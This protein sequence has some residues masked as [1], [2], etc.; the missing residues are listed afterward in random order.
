MQ[1][2]T[3]LAEL[4]RIGIDPVYQV[5]G[6][7]RD[8]LMGRP[9]SDYDFTTSMKPEEM[10]P[11]IQAAGKK[12]Y[13]IQGA[14]FGVV[15]ISLEGE[16]VEIASFR[17]ESYKENSRH[18]DVEYVTDITADL[19]RRDFSINAMAYRGHKLIDPFGGEQDIEAKLIRCVGSPRQRFNEDPLRMLR[20]VRFMAQLKFGIHEKTYT[21]IWEKAYKILTVSKERWMQE[22]DKI[23]LSDNA[24]HGLTMMY[25]LR[26]LNFMIPELSLQIG[27]DQHN[28]HHQHTLW[29]HTCLVV[30]GVPKDINLRW[31]ALL[32]DWAK[33]FIYTIK[34][35]PYR[36]TY[37]GHEKLGADMADRLGRHLKW[38]NERRKAVVDLIAN[39]MD[40]SSPLRQFDLSAH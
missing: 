5:G 26:L 34:Q 33:P 39:H 24:A 2:D 1:K 9:V 7:V 38:S 22:L 17:S 18:P 21:E 32:H 16:K 30:E 27:F 6:S 13:N 28:H 10:I 8:E 36:W 3:V 4:K 11:L 25:R 12:A 29:G 31:A 19:S 40:D 37:I 14:R 15:T 35:N 20:A 23:L